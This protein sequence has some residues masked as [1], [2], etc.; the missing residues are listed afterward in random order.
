MPG[1]IGHVKTV[2]GEAS[3]GRTPRVIVTDVAAYWT[4]GAEM[5][6]VAGD[7]PEHVCSHTRMWS[8]VVVVVG[9]GNAGS[10]A[11]DAGPNSADRTTRGSH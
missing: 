4:T 10:S 1:G 5:R 6:P 8:C 11:H 7:P 2:P 9:V 3:S